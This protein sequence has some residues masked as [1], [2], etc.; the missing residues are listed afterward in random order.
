MNNYPKLLYQKLWM[1]H[2][3]ISPRSSTNELLRIIYT[4]PKE[5]VEALNYRFI[6]GEEKRIFLEEGQGVFEPFAERRDVRVFK[7]RVA[8]ARLGYY[9]LGGIEVPKALSEVITDQG[10]LH[11]NFFH[12]LQAGSNIP[13]AESWAGVLWD[14]FGDMGNIVELTVWGASFKAYRVTIPKADELEGLI[15][16]HLPIFV[17][18]AQEEV[19][20]I[21]A[22]VKAKAA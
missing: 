13:L 6:T 3:I 15:L 14:I 19:E 22:E 18:S 7:E 9:Y 20:K 21:E 4:G 2:G 11:K 1:V 17:K 12:I 5:A 16:S 8:H 10:D